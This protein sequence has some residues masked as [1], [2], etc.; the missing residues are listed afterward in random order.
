MFVADLML[1]KLARWLRILGVDTVYPEVVEDEDILEL[2]KT[3]N[4][5]LLTQDVELASRAGGYGVESFLVPREDCFEKQV[6]AVLKRFEIVIDY[7]E[8]TL[9]P[10]CNGLL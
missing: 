5:V 6:A 7:P 2:A 1:K 10:Q 3:E 9:C 8:K 4:R